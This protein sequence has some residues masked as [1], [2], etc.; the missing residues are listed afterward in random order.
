MTP[1][2]RQ[3]LTGAIALGATPIL[4]QDEPEKLPHILD[5]AAERAKWEQLL[6][7]AEQKLE[8][9]QMKWDEERVFEKERWENERHDDMDRLRILNKVGRTLLERYV[10][11][12]DQWLN[13]S[14]FLAQPEIKKKENPF[15]D[16]EYVGGPIW[17]LLKITSAEPLGAIIWLKFSTCKED[18]GQKLVDDPEAGEGHKMWAP[19]LL[20]D[21]LWRKRDGLLDALEH[22]LVQLM[23]DEDCVKTM[24]D[25]SAHLYRIID[26]NSDPEKVTKEQLLA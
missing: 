9:A 14:G 24:K 13:N 11:P 8:L 12:L 19:E 25:G 10:A 3:F 16:P 2:R 23:D 22:H 20:I 6:A 7:D 4:A 18:I 15:D 5:F 17:F 21:M 1:S 26:E